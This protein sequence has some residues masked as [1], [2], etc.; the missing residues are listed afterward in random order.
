M[1]LLRGTFYIPRSAHTVYLCVLCESE[2]KQR[3][4]HFTTLTDWLVFIT[5]MKSVYCALRTG[6]LNIIQLV[7]VLGPVAILL[8]ATINFV[9]SL[10][11]SVGSQWADFHEIWYNNNF[12]KSVEKILVSLKTVDNNGTLHEDE[13]TFLSYLAQFF[14]QYD[15][16]LHSSHLAT[17]IA[18][19][20][21]LYYFIL[22][23]CEDHEASYFAVF[24]SLLLLSPACCYCLQPAVTFSSPLL[25]SP[26]W[27]RTFLSAPCS[28]L[29][30]HGHKWERHVK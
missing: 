23:F 12:Q 19:L 17:R 3:L 10:C 27:L 13:C 11:L 7:I 20:I 16:S 26:S 22:I 9:M 30:R 25:L 1:C 2:N 29:L 5:E 24:S 14:L 8:R 15:M 18:C 6:S 21:L 4:F 28:S